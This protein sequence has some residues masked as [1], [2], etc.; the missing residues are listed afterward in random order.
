MDKFPELARM[1]DS[2]FV[3]NMDN[4]FILRTGAWPEGYFFADKNGIATWK[5]TVAKD[6]TCGHFK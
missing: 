2:I 3:D 1:V 5:C 4:D 6:Q